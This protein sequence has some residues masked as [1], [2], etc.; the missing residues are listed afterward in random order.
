MIHN[1]VRNRRGPAI[2]L[3]LACMAALC[4]VFSGGSADGADDVLRNRVFRLRNT[5][6]EDVKKILVELG[7]GSDINILPQNSLIVTASENEV[8]GQAMRIAELADQR[9]DYQV[10]T[11]IEDVERQYLPSVLEQNSELKDYEIGNLSSPPVSTEKVNVMVLVAGGDLVAV[12]PSGMVDPIALRTIKL[13]S[14]NK[15]EASEPVQQFPPKPKEVKTQPDEVEVTVTLGDKKPQADEKAESAPEAAAESS[16]DALLDAL[17][18]AEKFLEQASAQSPDLVEEMKSEPKKEDSDA[19]ENI[20]KM[21]GSLSEQAQQ[22]GS[23]EKPASGDEEAMSSDELADLLMNMQGEGKE[24]E[25]K[26]AKS[27]DVSEM[28]PAEMLKSLTED[29]AKTGGQET[30]DQPA[31]PAGETK[32]A[33]EYNNPFEGDYDIDNPET[34]LELTITLPERVEL[35][36]LIELVGKQLGLN[37]V[38]DETQVRG[39]VTLKVHDGKIKVRDMYALL[40]S[41]LKFRGFAMSRRGNLVIIVPAAQIQ[42]YDPKIQEDIENIEPGN[43]VV[44]TT[45]AL[46]HIGTASAINL[47]TN[48]K[49]G[50]NVTPIAET[51]TLIVTGYAYRMPRIRKILDLV[52]VPGE[53]KV[54]RHRQLRYTIASNLAPRIQE[55]ASQ[56]EDVT[57]TIDKPTSAPASPARTTVV[58]RPTTRTPTPTPATPAQQPQQDAVFLNTDDRTN[59]IFMIGLESQV[60]I[61]EGL[62][63]ALDVQKQDLRSIQQYQIQF[64]GA[65]EVRQKLVELEIISSDSVRA[66]SRSSTSRTT[67][68]RTTTSRTPQ[69]QPAAINT[70]QAAENII[71]GEPQV[72]VLESTNSLLVNATPEQHTQIAMI[73]TYVD[74]QLE[75]Q[76]NPYVVYSLENQDPE[77]L[78]E[79]LQKVVE[80]QLEQKQQSDPQG[81]IQSVSKMDNEER[82]TIVP[83]KGTF[84][85]IVYAAKKYQEQIGKLI[86]ILDKRRPQVL[87]DVALV[88]ISRNDQFEYDLNVIANARDFVG[89]N[90]AVRPAF[91][92]SNSVGVD[93]LEGGWNVLGG[94]AFQG[95]YGAKH[96]QTLFTMM[97]SKGYGRVLAQPKLLANDNETGTIKTV[98][99]TYRSESTVAVDQNGNPVESREFSQF[100]AT[101][102]LEITPTI[103]E[104]DLLRLEITLTREDFGDTPI[105]GA[106]PNK[107]AT[108]VTT[109]VTVPD[110]KTIILGGLTKLNQSK[111]GSKVPLLGDLPLVGALFRTANNKDDANHLYIFVKSHIVR[112][113]DVTFGMERLKQISDGYRHQFEEQEKKFQFY[114]QFPDSKPEP[115]EPVRVL[116]DIAE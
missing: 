36:S 11:L 73:I 84:S 80:A 74:S 1:F 56:L 86:E 39:N 33:K 61:V 114:E 52:D 16:E 106:P 45:F 47:L 60:E 67:T 115:L 93:F 55:L 54:F 83:D 65:E 68:S 108:D 113:D 51:N 7:I 22:E 25:A 78:A 58:R 89:D 34:E 48:M 19:I 94:G 53:Q 63:D 62:I 88:E 87:I 10:R 111:G 21:L 112:P 35:T 24:A 105:E 104:G 13:Y 43:V 6:A 91:Q 49:L 32:T 97:D 90:V 102:Q 23:S 37:Y 82:I 29:M 46:D 38:Y 40:E 107:A 2:C 99:S 109:I 77:D 26:P 31:Q 27:E 92:D 69:P 81:K 3:L 28:S 12:A 4:V 30:A 14:Q 70:E 64:V 20:E 96:I 5:A 9:K 8:L 71:E 17:K 50:L 44:T 100:D 101:I 57:V 103:S 15:A 98:T 18:Q 116:E 41:V 42:D 95:F 59:R 75:E 72:V 79:V 85:I 66:S 76:A 110:S